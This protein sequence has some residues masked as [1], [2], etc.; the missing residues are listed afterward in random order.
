[1]INNKTLYLSLI[2]FFW[3]I[4]RLPKRHYRSFTY[5][6]QDSPWFLKILSVLRGQCQCQSKCS[7]HKHIPYL[8]FEA[9]SHLMKNKAKHAQLFVGIFYLTL[10][11]RVLPQ[12]GWNFLQSTCLQGASLSAFVL[13]RFQA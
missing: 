13:E 12:E 3:E 11:K 7:Y 4:I 10:Q 6:L 1:M 9:M 2:L 8:G 5:I